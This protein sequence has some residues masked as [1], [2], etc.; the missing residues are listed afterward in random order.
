MTPTSNTRTRLGA[1]VAAVWKRRGVRAAVLA[2]CL[3]VLVP[4]AM[5]PVFGKSWIAHGIAVAPNAGMTFSAEGDVL[6]E[7]RRMGIDAHWRVNV[8]SLGVATSMSVWIVEPRLPPRGTVIVLH[9]IRSDKSSVAGL[10]KQIAEQGYLVLVPDLPGHGRSSGDWLTYGVRETGVVAALLDELG[11]LG[12]LK[13]RVGIVGISYGAAVAI[14]LAAVDTRVRAVV[15][16]APFGSLRG[17][18]PHYVEHYLPLVGRLVPDAFIQE[19]VDQAGALAGFDPDEASPLRAISRT[20]AQILL[21]H[22]VCG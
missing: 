20:R 18:V 8:A 1:A 4:I 9:G 7:Q 3:L 19:G 21:S 12:R 5:V 2:V 10:A 11:A 22:S 14:Q 6:S 16:V 15:A 17:V 13:G